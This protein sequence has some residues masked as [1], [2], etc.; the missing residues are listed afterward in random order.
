[1]IPEIGV[2][3]WLSSTQLWGI[4]YYLYMIP[5]IGVLDWLSSIPNLGNNILPLYDPGNWGTRLVI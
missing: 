4:I 5:E 1:M 2:L 3:D